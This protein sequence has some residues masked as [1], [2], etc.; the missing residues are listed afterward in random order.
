MV[1]AIPWPLNPQERDLLPNVQDGG[2]V[3]GLVWTGRE[4]LVPIR[5]QALDC[6]AVAGCYT[7][8]TI[9]ATINDEYFKE[10]MLSIKDLVL[11]YFVIL[12]GG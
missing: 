11:I 12:K 9:P 8:Y 5:V 4:N 6:P 7:N 3:L 2:S 10:K 1:S